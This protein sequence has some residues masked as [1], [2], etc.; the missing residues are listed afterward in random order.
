MHWLLELHNVE[1]LL[2]EAEQ[3]S[4][5]NGLVTGVGGFARSI[6]K[7]GSISV[8]EAFGYLIA[9]AIGVRVPRMQ[10]VWMR[11]A[12]S[13][14]RVDAEPGRI[15]VL[16]EHHEAGPPYTQISQR[17]NSGLYSRVRPSDGNDTRLQPAVRG[18]CDARG[19]RYFSSSSDQRTAKRCRPHARRRGRSLKVSSVSER[20]R[21]QRS[22]ERP[23]HDVDAPEAARDR[24]VRETLVGLLQEPPSGL[25]AQLK[26]IAAW[27]D[28]ELL[29]EHP[30]EV[31]RAHRHAIG[32][33]VDRQAPVEVFHHPHL[34]LVHRL[35][36]QGLRFE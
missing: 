5:G 33:G 35:G 31:P 27:R 9:S 14:D 4:G 22:Q 21:P 34:Q 19:C 26:E 7:F 15:G 18:R 13:T 1:R 23:S 17:T 32:E 24:A 28:A 11:E 29:C 36:V 20:C 2:S 6:L 16:V 30:R 8:C 3:F 10:G 12:V 25:Y